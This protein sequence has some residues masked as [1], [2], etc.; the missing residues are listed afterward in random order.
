MPCDQVEHILSDVADALGHAHAQGI[1]HR[2]V[3]PENIFVDERSGRA[4]LSDFGIA[5]SLDTDTQLTSA[6]VTIG[7]PTY[8]A[9]EQIDD[10]VLDGR[11][12]LYSLGIVGWEML[13]GQRPWNG[14][15][16]YN[17]LYHQKCDALP[18]IDTIRPE[19]PTRLLAAVERLLE[20]SPSDRWS[21]AS[22]FRAQLTATTPVVRRVRVPR[23]VDSS[24]DTV[25]IPKASTA[26]PRGARLRTRL[27]QIGLPIAAG[28]FIVTRVFAAWP[29]FGARPRAHLT[30][31][32]HVPV[33]VAGVADAHTPSIEHAGTAA[34]LLPDDLTSG[35]RVLENDFHP[36]TSGESPNVTVPPP[37]ATAIANSVPALAIT[38]ST[39]ELR[40]PK[41]LLPTE[42]SPVAMPELI[43]KSTNESMEPARHFSVATG[44][45]HTCIV[46]PDGEIFCWGN[47]DR[48]QLGIGMTRRRAKETSIGNDHRFS[49]VALGLSHTCALT[50]DGNAYCWGSNEHGQLGDGATSQRST[51]TRVSGGRTLRTVTTGLTHSCALTLDG[52][53]LCWGNGAHGQLGTG[54]RNDHTAPTAVIT[55]A[56]FNAVVAGWNHTCALDDGGHAYCWGENDTGALGDGTTTDRQTPTPVRTSVRFV[57]LSAGSAHTCGITTSGEAYCWGQNRYGELGEGTTI[58]RLMPTP[59][60]GGMRFAAISAGGVHSCALTREHEAW[61]WGR[62]T[63]GQLGDG[64]STS[65]TSPVRVAGSHPFVTLHAFGAH[66]CGT[67]TADEL[68]CWGYNLDG[69]LG[70][71]TREHRLRPTYVEKPIK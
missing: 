56:K 7:T 57:M 67:T 44:V 8:M 36:V 29:S 51:P 11:S 48:G 61:C 6:G 55:G 60:E 33:Q 10:A 26:R 20:K 1:I 23:V 65:R 16:L 64:S 37:I 19:T 15:S 69:Q 9:P 49:T 40:A 32:A 30:K 71:G 70:D 54:E 66:S 63:Y 14:E 39:Q 2:D 58:N 13:T 42:P 45:S 31:R 17:I 59:V 46:S 38:H 4:L 27:L 5:R 18:P 22:E 47:D 52:G 62:N 28:V 12:D 24:M 3:K 68:F 50:T 53:V 34:V 21:S 43:R 25:I 35:T 41:T